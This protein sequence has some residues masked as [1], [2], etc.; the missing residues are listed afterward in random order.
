MPPAPAR[1]VFKLYDNPKDRPFYFD[2]LRR[3]V[4]CLKDSLYSRGGGP[5]WDTAAGAAAGGSTGGAAAAGS[6]TGGGGAAAAAAAGAAAGVGS[7]VPEL[8]VMA[9]GTGAQRPGRG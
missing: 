4:P 1:Q 7:E 8:G 6:A 9:P 5:I 3:M 2:C